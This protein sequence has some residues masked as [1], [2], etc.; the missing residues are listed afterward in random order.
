LDLQSYQLI[1]L[2]LSFDKPRAPVIFEDA[3]IFTSSAARNR[4]V[5]VSF[6]HEDFR[7]IYWFK[8]IMSPIEQTEPFNEKAKHPPETLKDSGILFYAYEP[9]AGI[10]SLEYRLIV[11]GLW[12][13]DPSNPA[14]RTS[15]TSGIEL[16]LSPVPPAKALVDFRDGNQSVT[17]DGMAL[18]VK[19]HAPSGDSVTVAGDFNRWDPFM[20]RLRETRIGEYELILPLPAG[21]YRYVIYHNGHQ[22]VDPY[23]PNKEYAPGG[24]VVNTV[25]LE[26]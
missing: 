18:Y 5:G 16:S 10:E 1:D 23:N 4:K 8:K 2:L 11:D 22:V 13:T 20:Y 17:N 26:G 7:K 3:V 15:F 24:K 14:R 12:T 6:A 21:K 19:Y 25:T 9:P